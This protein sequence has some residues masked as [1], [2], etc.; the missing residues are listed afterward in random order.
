MATPA[1]SQHQ[2]DAVE[3]LAEH[4]MRLSDVNF[5][6]LLGV[7]EPNGGSGASSSSN[8]H[9]APGVHRRA[10]HIAAAAAVGRHSIRHHPGHHHASMRHKAPPLPQGPCLCDAHRPLWFP[11]RTP[12]ARPGSHHGSRAPWAR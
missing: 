1:S 10:S 7:W 8:A 5:A 6:S 4:V 2:H 11:A 9:H 12:H 3:Q